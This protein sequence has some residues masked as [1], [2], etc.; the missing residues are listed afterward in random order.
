V[1]EEHQIPIVVNPP[2]AQAL[3]KGAEVGDEIPADL[4]RAVAEILAHI[5][6]LTQGVSNP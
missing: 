2:L 1:A 5:Y 3:Y 6:R 4:Y